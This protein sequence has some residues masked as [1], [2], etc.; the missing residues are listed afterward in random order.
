MGYCRVRHV[1]A[2]NGENDDYGRTYRQRAVLSQI[3]SKVM[4]EL[5]ATEAVNL[6]YDLLDYVAT[7]ISSGDLITY[8]KCVL[9]M[10]IDPSKL[11]QMRIPMNNSFTSRTLHCGSSLCLDWTVNQKELWNFLYGTEER[12]VYTLTP[13]SYSSSYTSST[14]TPAT[15]NSNA[16]T[17]TYAPIVTSAPTQYQTEEPIQVTQKPVVVTE[18]PV[19]TEAPV[20]TEAPVITEA[21]VVT[22]VPVVV[23]EPPAVAT[24]VPQ[25]PVSNEGEDSVG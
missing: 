1:A 9:S 24:E 22:E 19:I 15:D 20:V 18:A 14:Y 25:Q 5:S 8:A 10:G 17:T 3:Y 7:D 12:E 2:I 23:T 6:A 11:E 16:S 4:T 13:D 21:P